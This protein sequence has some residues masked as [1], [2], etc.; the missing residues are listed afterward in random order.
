MN[1]SRTIPV[2]GTDGLEKLKTSKIAIFGIGG[3]GGYALE[4]LVRAGAEDIFLI[5]YDTVDPSNLNRQILFTTEDVDK[6]KCDIAIKRIKKINPNCKITFSKE[7]ITTEN[8][9]T[10]IPSNIEF[11]I[12]AIDDVEAK[13]KLIEHLHKNNIYFISSMGAGNRLDPTKVEFADISK[14]SVCPLARSVR[15]KLR[16]IEIYKGVPSIFST[17]NSIKNS[18]NTI[19]SISFMPGIFGLFAAGKLIK[20][21]IE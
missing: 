17:E 3:V 10:L 11:A 2:I 8:I 13:V 4:S 14:T 9:K 7:K 12:D 5:D 19:G 21:I 1:H 18:E 6:S 16:E 20:K 15:K